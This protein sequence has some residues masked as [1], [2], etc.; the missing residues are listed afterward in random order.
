MLLTIL[1]CIQITKDIWIDKLYNIVKFKNI[2][3]YQS[4]RNKQQCALLQKI[5]FNNVNVSVI[6]LPV[7]IIRNKDEIWVYCSSFDVN[8]HHVIQ[9]EHTGSPNIPQV[10]Q[11]PNNGKELCALTKILIKMLLFPQLSLLKPCPM[12]KG[13]KPDAFR[14]TKSCSAKLCLFWTLIWSQTRILH[15]LAKFLCHALHG[16]HRLRSKGPPDNSRRA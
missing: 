13:F 14:K 2:I 1:K 11:C 9:L 16:L 8:S 12:I 6:F 7:C 10:S 5:I 4:S 3:L 15:C